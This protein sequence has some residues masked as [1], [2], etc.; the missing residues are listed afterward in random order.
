M[1]GSS[2]GV[3]CFLNLL[4]LNSVKNFFLILY[5][6]YLLDHIRPLESLIIRMLIIKHYIGSSSLKSMPTT[7]LWA[8]KDANSTQFCHNGITEAAYCAV[9]TSSG[10]KIMQLA[11][12]SPVY[13]MTWEPIYCNK[14]RAQGPQVPKVSTQRQEKLMGSS[15]SEI[16]PQLCY[17][18]RVCFFLRLINC[19]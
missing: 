14:E 17:F 7:N 18:S 9:A 5:L 15:H 6:F 16:F 4:L 10:L 3:I 13:S 12:L 1:G 8:C 2:S 19:A 11:L